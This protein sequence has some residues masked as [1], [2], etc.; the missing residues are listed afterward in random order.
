MFFAVAVV[1]E[2]HPKLRENGFL[3]CLVACLQHSLIGDAAFALRH[4]LAHLADV[5]A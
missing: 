1:V 2:K 5:F 3:L 4:S